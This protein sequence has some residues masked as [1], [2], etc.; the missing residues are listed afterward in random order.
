[1]DQEHRVRL[2]E[3]RQIRLDTIVE[4]LHHMA[5]QSDAELRSQGQAIQVLHTQVDGIRTE[6]GEVKDTV[7]KIYQIL[8]D[9]EKELGTNSFLREWVGKIW[10]LFL[11]ALISF[12]ISHLRAVA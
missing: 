9:R 12:L 2:L 4:M 10:L 6:L 11:G 1:M 5:K 3:E 8:F 7:Q